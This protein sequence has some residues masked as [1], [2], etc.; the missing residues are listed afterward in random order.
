[1]LGQIILD[2]SRVIFNFYF[3]HFCKIS[4]LRLDTTLEYMLLVFCMDA[5]FS[6]EKERVV[7]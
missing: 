5:V 7:A 2:S 4:L 6:F 3:K 1:M